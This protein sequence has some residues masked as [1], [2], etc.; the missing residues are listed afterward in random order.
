MAKSPGEHAPLRP[1]TKAERDA[2]QAFGK[3]K[4]GTAMS[5]FETEQASFNNNRERLK[6]ERLAREALEPTETRK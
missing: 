1:L 5:D 6:A 3:A 2:R 4:P